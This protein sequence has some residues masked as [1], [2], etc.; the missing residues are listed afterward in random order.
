MLMS[1]IAYADTPDV[2]Y[3]YFL[4]SHLLSF[5]IISYLM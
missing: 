4:E 1:Y 2:S 3:P 5:I